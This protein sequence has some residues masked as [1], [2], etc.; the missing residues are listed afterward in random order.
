MFINC[1]INDMHIVLF[2]WNVIVCLAR[3]LE[4]RCHLSLWKFK[5]ANQ[6]RSQIAWLVARSRPTI[7]ST[8][9]DRV[10]I[11]FG[12]L[13]KWA[14]RLH[15]QLQLSLKIPPQLHVRIFSFSALL[16]KNIYVWTPI[17]FICDF[18]PD[19]R[20]HRMWRRGNTSRRHSLWRRAVTWQ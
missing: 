2:Y 10:T 18:G 3:E 12:V 20:R 16:L 19:T 1:Y 4:L 17:N 5:R 8:Y 6:S 7:F 15:S 14:Q 11:V 13:H 9:L